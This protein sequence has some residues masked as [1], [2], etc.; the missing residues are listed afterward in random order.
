MLPISSVL[1]PVSTCSICPPKPLFHP[2]PVFVVSSLGVTGLFSVRVAG[3][4]CE[5]GSLCVSQDDLVA[6]CSRLIQLVKTCC[7]PI[8]LT[9]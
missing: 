1:V 2:V 8:C 9:Y 7:G 5:D 4:I 6:V 3:A